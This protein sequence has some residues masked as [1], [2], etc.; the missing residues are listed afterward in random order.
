M[1]AEFSSFIERVFE[2]VEKADSPMAK[3]WLS[4]MEWLKYWSCTYMLSGHKTGM[5]L[6]HPSKWWCHGCGYTITTNTASGLLSSGS[7]AAAYLWEGKVHARRVNC[8]I[9]DRETILMFT[10]GSLDREDDELRIKGKGWVEEHLEKWENALYP[11]K[12]I[13]FC[14]QSK[15]LT[16]CTGK[17]QSLFQKPQRKF[18]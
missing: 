3:F 9:D 1:D 18:H 7:R 17:P 12:N 14:E 6:K 8:P 10:S 5:H 15:E 4:F 13:W 2:S 16:T 11:H